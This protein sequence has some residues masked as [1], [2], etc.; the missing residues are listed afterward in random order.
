MPYTEER[1]I[2]PPDELL[3]LCS[4]EPPPNKEAFLKLSLEERLA[5]LGRVYMKQTKN[6]GKC[7]LQLIDLNKWIAET[8]ARIASKGSTQ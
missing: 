8:K 4:V 2:S 3:V 6:V 1:F 5:V 7:N